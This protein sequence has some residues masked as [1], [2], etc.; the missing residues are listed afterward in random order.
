MIFVPQNTSVFVKSI[1]GN[2]EAAEFNGKLKTELISGNVEI[3][4][5]QGV[6]D[7]KTVSGNLDIVITKADIEAQTVTDVIYSNLE[8]NASEKENKGVGAHIKGRVNNGKEL[9][10]LETVS[11]N[12]YLRKG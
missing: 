8:F 5:Y 6:M 7:L 12:I 11:G 3:K 1:S 10:R 4:Q 2:L 9:L